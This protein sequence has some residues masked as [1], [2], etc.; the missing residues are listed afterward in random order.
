MDF[1]S[2]TAASTTSTTFIDTV[3]QTNGKIT[4]TKKTL[5]SASTSVAGIVQLTNSVS[6]SSTTTAATPANVKS[7]Y[8]LAS[9]ASSKASSNETKLGKTWQTTTVNKVGA[10][11]T[12]VHTVAASSLNIAGNDIQYIIF[13]CG[14]STVNI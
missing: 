6:S 1:S 4:A 3:S 10:N 8:D 12:T 11:S 9:A 2:P 5:P 13:D 14:S 7:A